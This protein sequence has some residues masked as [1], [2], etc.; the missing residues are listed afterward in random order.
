MTKAI[1]QILAPD[2]LIGIIQTV[3]NGIP[4]DILPAGLFVVTERFTG[5]QGRYNKVAGTQQAATITNYGS[6]AQVVN[7]WGIGTIPVTLLHS[8]ES[9]NFD[10]Q[11]LANLLAEDSPIRQAMGRQTVE[12]NLANFGTR[13]RNLKISSVHSTLATGRIYFDA[14][15]NLLPKSTGATFSL[16]FGVSANHRKQLAGIIGASWATATTDI[17]QHLEALQADALQTTGKAIRHAFYGK[18]VP[19]LLALNNYVSTLYLNPVLSQQ[20]AASTNPIPNGLFGL[21][22]HPGNSAFYR[23]QNNDVQSWFPSDQIV[24]TPEPD[25]EWWGFLEGSYVIP[26]S[27]QLAGDGIAALSQFSEVQGDFG[28]ASVS[29]NPPGVTQYGGSTFLPVLKNPDAI[30]IA[31]VVP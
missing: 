13:L 30:Y 4:A 26:N 24:F 18:A 17:P 25:G 11:D 19:G 15:G 16:D 29:T 27:I 28:F 7:K 1:S 3:A 31:D 10:P 2:N 5:N 6:P 8:F 9:I 21:D 22:W 20:R 14:A 23:D 12:R